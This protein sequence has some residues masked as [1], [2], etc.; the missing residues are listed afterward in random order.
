MFFSHAM[1]V[2]ESDFTNRLE[3]GQKRLPGFTATVVVG[4]YSTTAD[5][6]S[7]I[8]LTLLL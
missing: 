2:I 7:L 3:G 1:C 4:P 6:R 5:Y 8:L